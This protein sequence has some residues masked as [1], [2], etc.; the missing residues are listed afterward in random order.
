MYEHLSGLLKGVDNSVTPA[1]RFHLNDVLREYADIFS[2]GELDLGDTSLT[3]HRID[4]GSAPPTRQTLRRQPYHLL[5]K[6]DAHVKDMIKVGVIEPSR[7]P[8]TSNIVVVNK[9]D[10][11]LRFCIDYRL[12]SSYHQVPMHPDDADKTTFVVRT[13]TYPFRKMSFGLCNAGSTFQRVMDMAL[14]GLNFN[15]CLVYIDNIIVFSIT[16]EEHIDRLKKVFDRMRIANLKFKHSKCHLLQTKVSFLGHIVS[17]E[18]VSTDPGKIQAVKE[19]PVPQDV[20]EVR[21]FLGMASYYRQFVPF[22]AAVAS[23]LHTLSTKNQRFNWTPEYDESFEQ[24]KNALVTSPVLAMPNDHDFFILDTDACDVSVGAVL[25]QVQDG[26]E[27]VIAY[28]SRSLSKQER[29]YCVTRKK[30]LAVVYYAR[31]FRQYLLGRKFLIRTDHSALQWLRSTP[32]PIGQQARWYEILEEFDFQIV[33]RPGRNHGNA[34]TLSR[35]PCRQCGQETKTSED[36]R[37]RVI[38]FVDHR[39]GSRWDRT[40]IAKSTELDPLI[41]QIVKWINDHA[42]PIDSHILAE[43]DPVIKSL[44]SQWERFTV[45]KGVL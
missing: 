38:N 16:V 28:A 2:T 20:K 6:K 39:G 24:L 42:L 14:N 44:H 12:R 30:L 21:S 8:W 26:M 1:Q 37:V 27:R 18:G 36:M 17:G 32:E 4:T 7:S 40:E 22:F 23:P 33:H 35:R 45:I 25:S 15:M 19:W 10:D 34:D 5:E 29:N 31:A 9:K 43:M 41:G 13:G 11:S 3:Q